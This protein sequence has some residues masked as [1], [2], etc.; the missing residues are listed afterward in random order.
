MTNSSVSQGSEFGVKVHQSFPEVVSYL[1]NPFQKNN[2]NYAVKNNQ[3]IITPKMAS[4]L[5]FN[6]GQNIIGKQGRN[7]MQKRAI[8][9][10][11]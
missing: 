10:K 1:C 8:S 9:Y 4:S 6:R 3:A 5:R 11:N 2:L 7:A